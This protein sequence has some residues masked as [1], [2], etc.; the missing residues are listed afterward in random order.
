MELPRLIDL[1]QQLDPFDRLHVNS[2]W[3]ETS[4]KGY[5][6][7]FR[8]SLYRPDDPYYPTDET[9]PGI[10]TERLPGVTAE[11]VTLAPDIVRYA[12]WHV[13]IWEQIEQLVGDPQMS[14]EINLGIMIG[15]EESR[16]IDGE[17]ANDEARQYWRISTHGRPRSPERTRWMQ[18][19]AHSV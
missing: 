3:I 14:E 17:V 7:E 2:I 9:V 4:A 5:K 16:I 1:A 8:R 19:I 12:T 13:P 15:T 11:A 18:R 6:V 10:V